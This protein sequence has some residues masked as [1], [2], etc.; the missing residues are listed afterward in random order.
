MDACCRAV[1]DAQRPVT[2]QDLPTVAEP[3]FRARIKAKHERLDSAMKL[4]TT[5]H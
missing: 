2:A 3:S 1:G 5:R 4:Q